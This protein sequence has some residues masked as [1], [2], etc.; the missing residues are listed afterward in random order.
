MIELPLFSLPTN[1]MTWQQA[2][3]L[4]L[5][6]PVFE[7]YV[8][9]V[10]LHSRMSG[11]VKVKWLRVGVV[12][13]VFGAVHLPRGLVMGLAVIPAGL[14]LGWIYERSMSWRHCAV[15]H[16]ALNGLWLVV[17]FFMMKR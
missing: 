10:G 7:E 1:G 6:A 5:I 11:L 12:A 4:L 3:L 14:L 8:L 17:L 16:S 9:R 2:V 15:M 13:M